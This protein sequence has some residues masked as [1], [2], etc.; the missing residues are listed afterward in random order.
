VCVCVY[1]CIAVLLHRVRRVLS[2]F[3]SRLTSVLREYEHSGKSNLSC[4]HKL[5]IL[6]KFQ[7]HTDTIS[8][9]YIGDIV[10]CPG[11]RDE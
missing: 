9:N 5:E 4:E 2:V 3:I 10:T 11:F 8:P 7:Q 1:P 6:I